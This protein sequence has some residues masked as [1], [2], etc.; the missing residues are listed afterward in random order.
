[1]GKKQKEEEHEKESGKDDN[2]KVGEDKK[3]VGK[4]DNKEVE[5]DE[6]KVYC[7]YVDEKG[8]ACVKGYP[9]QNTLN[10][11]QK[12][13]HRAWYNKR[14]GIEKSEDDEGKVHTVYCDIV[15]D[16]GVVCGRPFD[17]RN[18]LHRHQRAKH[19]AEYVGTPRSA[20]STPSKR[21]KLGSASSPFSSPGQYT[22]GKAES[23]L[24]ASRQSKSAP[25]PVSSPV[26]DTE[27]MEGSP[28]EAGG[29][30]ESKAEGGSFESTQDSSGDQN[31][32]ESTA[33]QKST[34]KGVLGGRDGTRNMVS[35]LMVVSLVKGLHGPSM[36]KGTQVLNTGDACRGYLRKCTYLL[37][38]DTAK[39]QT[40]YSQTT[41]SS[42]AHEKPPSCPSAHVCGRGYT[43]KGTLYRHQRNKHGA[44]HQRK[45]RPQTCQSPD[46]DQTQTKL[47]ELE[48]WDDHAHLADVWG[49]MIVPEKQE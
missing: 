49:W 5:K 47:E 43:K 10:R 1:M 38:K 40:S 12:T 35:E 24:G 37:D 36:P 44:T 3:K 27:D 39:S 22:Q 16:N 7:D 15:D 19:D 29:G 11:H 8:V 42:T 13:Q 18:S 26:R 33:H 25:R 20:Q 28:S 4:E 6:N 45:A 17:H 32:D 14:H 31:G 46:D 9:Q 48:S 41:L 2:K 21:R 34:D 23:V 30:T